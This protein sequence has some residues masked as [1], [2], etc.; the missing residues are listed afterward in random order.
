MA[1]PPGNMVML[2]PPG[3]QE[4]CVCFLA[5]CGVM[6]RCPQCPFHARYHC[7][8]LTPRHRCRD[9]RTGKPRATQ[10]RHRQDLNPAVLPLL[11]LERDSEMY[12]HE[13]LVVGLRPGRA[14]S[15]IYTI[16]YFYC[17]FRRGIFLAFCTQ[18]HNLCN[19]FVEIYLWISRGK[20]V[21]NFIALLWIWFSPDFV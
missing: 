8:S 13:L 9:R 7:S 21:M 2:L 5:L 15:A 1:S 20:R 11:A 3:P 6:S 10:K 4:G 14:F 18:V 16:R 12:C 17:C 19:V